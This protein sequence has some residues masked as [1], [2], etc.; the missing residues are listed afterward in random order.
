MKFK[1]AA[2][3][4]IIILV[5]IVGFLSGYI[6]GRE[7]GEDS[8]RVTVNKITKDMADDLSNLYNEYAFNIAWECNE[9]DVQTLSQLTEFENMLK[10]N[11]TVVTVW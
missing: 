8:C 6:N 2:I 5:L 1:T 4:S 3:V 7:K 9:I 10:N 11:C